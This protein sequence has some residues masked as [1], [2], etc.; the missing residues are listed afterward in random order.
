MLFNRGAIILE[1]QSRYFRLRARFWSIYTIILNLF[2]P[3]PPLKKNESIPTYILRLN[4]RQA[5]R[6]LN[7]SIGII[8]SYDI[9][10]INYMLG[11]KDLSKEG[12]EFFEYLKEQ[13]ELK[14][15]YIYLREQIRNSGN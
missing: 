12:R 14:K 8:H 10:G 15:L 3:A 7:F 6:Q 1:T 5:L 11:R 9:G 2:D 13:S 4:K